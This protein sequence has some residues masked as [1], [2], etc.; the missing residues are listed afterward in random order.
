MFCFCFREIQDVFLIFLKIAAKL[1]KAFKV[2]AFLALQ[3]LAATIIRKILRLPAQHIAAERC[4]LINLFL[5][6]P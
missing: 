6:A 3:D 5:A 4:F 2:G 1:N